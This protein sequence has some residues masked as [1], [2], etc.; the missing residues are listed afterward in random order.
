MELGIRYKRGTLDGEIE[1]SKEPKGGVVRLSYTSYIVHGN[2]TAHH[3][4]TPVVTLRHT[5]HQGHAQCPSALPLFCASRSADIFRKTCFLSFYTG[6]LE[7]AAYT[8]CIKQL[9]A[10]SD[11]ITRD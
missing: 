7:L 11:N 4:H 5:P 9:T 6:L 3:F 1:T 8:N 10:I 2:T